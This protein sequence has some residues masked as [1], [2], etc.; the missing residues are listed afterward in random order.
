MNWNVEKLRSLLANKPIS[1]KAGSMKA[2]KLAS[3][4]TL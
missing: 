2:S 3:M 4:K 1:L